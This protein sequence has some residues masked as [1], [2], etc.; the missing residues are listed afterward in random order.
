[1]KG[2]FFFLSLEESMVSYW[3]NLRSSGECAIMFEV[4]EE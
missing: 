3:M 1:M 4:M 2:L